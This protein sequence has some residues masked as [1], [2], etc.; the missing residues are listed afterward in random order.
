V[1]RVS[2]P[3]PRIHRIGA[4]LALAT[5]AMSLAAFTQPRD[6]EGKFSN[7]D[8]SEPKGLGTALKWGVWD[9]ITGQRR[10]TPDRAPIPTVAAD[11]A[12][13]RTP[14]AP[15]EP[16]RVTWLGHATFLVQLDG[17]SLLT[18][19]ALM[20]KLFGGIERNVPPG[21]AIED[22]PKIDAVLV[23]H[24]HYDHLDLPTVQKVGAPA[25]AGLGLERWFRDRHVFATEL[26]WWSSTRV[27][28]VKITFVPSQ[29]WSRRG[30]FD[31][32]R[33]LWGGFV[34]EGS[35]ATIYH[36]GDTAYF[37]GFKEIGERFPRID[38]ALLPIGAYDPAWF[39]ETMHLNPE[40]AL[41][42]FQDL[43]A[44]T[45]VAMHWGTFKLADEP[46]D[47]PPH[48]LDAERARLGLAPERVRVLAVGETLEV[49][50]AA[51]GRAAFQPAAP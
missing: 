13:L 1:E 11:V 19:P 30:L 49:A 31:T 28:P 39:M 34:I 44:R 26:G 8:R 45:F 40:Q 29:H 27:G 43:G 9:R 16:A 7:L 42:A 14:P 20:P 17:V 33:T 36:S 5:I 35:R 2:R 37:E 6:D 24:S 25:I 12:R 4:V 38:A 23:S 3:A 46:L 15:G 47:E 51:A 41:R 21:I 18:D 48:R 32:N 50:H 22:L 10:K